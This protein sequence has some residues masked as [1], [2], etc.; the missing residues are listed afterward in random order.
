MSPREIPFIR[1][2][3]EDLEP[4]LETPASYREASQRLL[5]V[6]EIAYDFVVQ[7]DRPRMAMQQVGFAL[8][9]PAASNMS[10]QDFALLNQVTRQDFSKGVTK[11][12]R[13][14]QLPPSFGSKSDEAKFAY[15]NCR[16]GNGV[17]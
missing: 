4:E 8:G 9:I 10:E 13:V 12:L 6:L 15:R 14:S 5:Y 16:N 11:F 2:P 17:A 3:V 1:H 7:S